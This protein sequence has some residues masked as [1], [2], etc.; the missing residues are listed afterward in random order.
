V[1]DGRWD[2]AGSFGAGPLDRLGPLVVGG[3][4]GDAF[5]AYGRVLGH[6]V[7]TVEFEQRRYELPAPLGVWG[8]IKIAAAPGRCRLPALVS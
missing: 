2:G 1:E 7:V 3:R 8:F 5:F 6:K 4:L